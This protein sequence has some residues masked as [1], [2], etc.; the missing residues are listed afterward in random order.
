MC[1]RY[2]WCPVGRFL[3]TNLNSLINTGLFKLPISYCVILV[4]MSFGEFVKFIRIK[5]FKYYY[6]FNI[7]RICS[8]FSFILIIYFY[9]SRGLLIFIPW[10]SHCSIFYCFYIFCFIDLPSDLYYILSSVYFMFH[11]SF[12]KKHFK[13]GTEVI[14]IKLLKSK[15]GS[16]LNVPF[17]KYHFAISHKVWSVFILIHF[18]YFQFPFWLL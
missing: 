16:L 18:K 7:C 15:V 14:N 8:H 5:L 1:T 13:V 10:K 11:F 17:L 12:L 3:A 4:N 6:S 9:P 2:I